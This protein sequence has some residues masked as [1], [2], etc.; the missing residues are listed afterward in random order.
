MQEDYTESLLRVLNGLGDY[1]TAN[2]KLKKLIIQLLEERNL[3]KINSYF[4]Q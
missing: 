1:N 2:R 4:A 3:L